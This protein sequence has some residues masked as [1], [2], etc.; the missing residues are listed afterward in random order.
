MIR[1]VFLFFLLI[2]A[3]QGANITLSS[4]NVQLDWVRHYSSGNDPSFD[5]AHAITVDASGNVYV[6]GASYGANGLYDYATMKYSSSGSVLWVA[7]FNGPEDNWDS[8]RAIEVDASGN[9]YVTGESYGSNYFDYVTIKYNSSGSQQ[10]VARYNSGG[11]KDL[12]YDLAVDSSGNVYVTGASGEGSYNLSDYVTIKYNSSGVQQWLARYHNTYD[13]ATALAID[14]SGNVYVTGYSYGS[15]TYYDYAT[16]KYNSKGQKR[17]VARYH[18]GVG[19]DFSYALAV[20]SSGN[21]Y[22]TGES[23]GS[24]TG[25]DYATIKYSPT[26][27][28]QWLARYD[29]QA[30]HATDVGV[31]IA[32][33]GSGNVYVTGE[34]RGSETK[35]DFATIKYGPQ[36]NQKWLIRFDGSESPFDDANA[37][38][39]DA[40]GNVYVTGRSNDLG[41]SMY[42]T[43]KYIQSP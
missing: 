42:T 7:R 33:D 23:V 20:D 11:G 17:W 31:A 43:V 26:G 4:D 5:F 2:F 40:S 24:G 37:L 1:K 9:V 13:Y 38:A 36:G 8:A 14:A 41:Y 6:T 25:G 39:I 27:K 28:R 3:I 21:V 19:D 10:W 15:G 16:I 34:S 35:D 12:A 30:G 32:V 18:G 29:G 22:V